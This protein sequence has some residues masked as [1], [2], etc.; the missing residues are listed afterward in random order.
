MN[1]GT[2]LAKKKSYWEIWYSKLEKRHYRIS[3]GRRYRSYEQGGIQ[4]IDVKV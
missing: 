2:C 1:K 3:T 4:N